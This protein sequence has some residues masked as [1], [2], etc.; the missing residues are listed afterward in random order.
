MPFITLRQI[1]Y[2]KA[3]HILLSL[4]VLKWEK[5]ERYFGRRELYLHLDLQYSS[6]GMAS[7]FFYWS[8]WSINKRLHQSSYCTKQIVTK[9]KCYS[10]SYQDLGICFI[11]IIYKNGIQKPHLLK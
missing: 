2:M 8:F 1:I 3:K 6:F 10:N 11:I 9:R 4:L 5:Y 7:L